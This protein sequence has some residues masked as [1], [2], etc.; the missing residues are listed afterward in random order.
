MGANTISAFAID[1]ANTV[2]FNKCVAHANGE[3]VRVTAPSVTD[4]ST[5]SVSCASG[6][7][8]LVSGDIIGDETFT[9]DPK[10]SNIDPTRTNDKDWVQWPYHVQPEIDTCYVIVPATDLIQSDNLNENPKSCAYFINTAGDTYEC[11]RCPFG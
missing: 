1:G 4:K 2:D 5:I 9:V 3:K 7:L 11:L 6:T 8:P 10:Y